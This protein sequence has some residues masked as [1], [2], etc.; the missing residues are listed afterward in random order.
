MYIAPP[1]SNLAISD[2]GNGINW[3][4]FKDD[5]KGEAHSL[6]KIM[7]LYDFWTCLSFLFVKLHS[8][9]PKDVK[10]NYIRIQTMTR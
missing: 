8:F 6:C 7:Q 10:K 2:Q 4:W 1:I 5:D 9:V 3:K